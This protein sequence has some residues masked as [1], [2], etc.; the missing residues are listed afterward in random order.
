MRSVA[1]VVVA[2]VVVLALAFPCLAEAS[3]KRVSLTSPVRAGSYASLSV[4]VSPRSRCTIQVIYDT[5][6][7]QAKGL[8]AKTGGRISW[9]WRV[10]TN[11]HP[12]SWPIIVKCGAAGTLRTKIR[13]RSA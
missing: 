6:V 2:I 1:T 8:G 3:V 9:R 11:T 13:V 12:G 7:S 5:V 10:G 4:N